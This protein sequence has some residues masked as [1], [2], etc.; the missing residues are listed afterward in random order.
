MLDDINRRSNGSFDQVF[1]AIESRILFLI[2]WPRDHARGE[3]G[4]DASSIHTGKNFSCG[5]VLFA[6]WRVS[7]LP[8]FFFYIILADRD[9]TDV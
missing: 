1:K 6:G 5:Y 7:T 8:M 3:I 2:L 4:A 9:L